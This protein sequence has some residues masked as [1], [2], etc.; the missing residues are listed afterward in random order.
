M[1]IEATFTDEVPKRLSQLPRVTLLIEDRISFE[2]FY[3][4]Q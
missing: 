2:I 4:I 1:D 3:L